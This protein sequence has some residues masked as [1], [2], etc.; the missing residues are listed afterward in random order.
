MTRVW[1]KKSIQA[2]LA[3]N[4][5]AVWKAIQAIYARQTDDEKDGG[6]KHRNGVGFG[7]WDAESFCRLAR[8][9]CFTR[10]DAAYARLLGIKRYWRQLA[11]IANENELRKIREHSAKADFSWNTHS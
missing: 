6:T 10:E 8:V 4:D 7:A 9:E 3:R 11:E 1:N 5:L 2:L